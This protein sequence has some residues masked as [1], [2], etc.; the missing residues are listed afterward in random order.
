MCAVLP[1]Q[2][3]NPLAPLQTS[4]HSQAHNDVFLDV[5]RDKYPGSSDDGEFV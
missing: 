5:I 4:P 2:D 3:Q 1:C